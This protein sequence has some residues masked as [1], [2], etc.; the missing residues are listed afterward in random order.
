MI[1]HKFLAVSKQY[2]DIGLKSI[3]IMIIA[4]I[5][6]F[7]RNNCKCYMTNKQFANILRE[8]ESTVKRSIQKLEKLNV[9][10]RYTTTIAGNGK[11]TKQRVL[12]LNKYEDWK[13]QIEPTKMVRSNISNGRVKNDKWEGHNDLIKDNIKDKE[14]DNVITEEKIQKVL[15][16]FSF[17]DELQED[18]NF[19]LISPEKDI[20]N[21]FYSFAFDELDRLGNDINF[22]VFYD[23]IQ[24]Y[25][26]GKCMGSYYGKW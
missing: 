13:G 7:E 14:K 18:I 21:E 4:Q 17:E 9:I 8:S 11:T 10:T 15:G 24:S 6:E 5:E 23:K 25:S 1:E 2:L 16:L 3:D 20:S 19:G 22:V 12:S 26:N